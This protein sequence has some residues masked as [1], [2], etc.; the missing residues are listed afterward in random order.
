MGLKWL[1][2]QTGNEEEQQK[3][4]REGEGCTKILTEESWKERGGRERESQRMR[5]EISENKGERK[6]LDLLLA[7]TA[8]H[9]EIRR[10]I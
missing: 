7:D 5:G 1:V 10:G 8:R 3:G 6:L 4:S 2:N 9:E